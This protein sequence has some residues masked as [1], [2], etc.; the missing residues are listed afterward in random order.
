MFVAMVYFLIASHW[1]RQ[2]GA[3]NRQVDTDWI[4]KKRDS[5]AFS[6]LCF[7]AWKSRG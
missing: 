6:L 3:I 7:D 2:D 1:Q 5:I 4:H